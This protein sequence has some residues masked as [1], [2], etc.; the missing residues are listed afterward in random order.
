MSGFSFGGQSSAPSGG[1]SF[2]NN[3]ASTNTNTGNTGGG[4]SFGNNASTGFGNTGG[5]SL[6]GNTTQNAST[7]NASSGTTG[8]TGNT[9]FMFG[10]TANTNTGTAAPST[11]GNLFGNTNSSGTGQSL[12]GNNSK[13]QSTTGSNLFSANNQSGTTGGGFSFGA[14]T[15][16]NTATTGGTSLF[17]GNSQP[18]QQTQNTQPAQSQ[19]AFNSQPSFAWSTQQS[20]QQSLH[21]M[22]VE[23]QKVNQQQNQQQNG[24]TPTIADQLTKVKNSW[25][26][27]SN[28][29]LMKT[30]VYN[31]V[32]QEYNNYERPADESAEDWENAMKLRPRGYN[33]LPVRIKGFED[34]L[35]R[36]NLQIEH[37]RKSRILLNN[38][39]S[40]LV[41]L[42]DKHD[43]DSLNRLTRCKIKQKQLDLKLLRIAINLTVLKYKGYQL[44]NDEE[45]LISQFKELVK[46]VDDPIGLN[47]SNELWARLSNLKQRLIN[48]NIS[49]D[50]ID[51][52]MAVATNST[53]SKSHVS[54]DEQVI[55]K[56]VSIL[57]KQQ[58]G[59][60]FLYDLI[61][62]D[63]EVV[64]KLAK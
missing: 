11:Q 20:Q 39:N 5:F 10:N 38:I 29:C 25:D 60:Q 57:S 9:G 31:K 2:G 43:L 3:N 56:L 4:F 12:F 63:K 49:L 55:S 47:R 45:K 27:N 19:P 21:P 24:Y 48:L 61:E 23:A 64:N 15:G 59:I 51:A 41:N 1:F 8:S 26:A 6:G 46:L 14:N 13:A 36:S 35:N 52:S 33:T 50:N 30:F 34:L 53:V 44:T 18:A 62:N 37:I 17:G 7:Q 40:N 32:P 22:V 16:S 54:N 42:G 28:Q 58:Q